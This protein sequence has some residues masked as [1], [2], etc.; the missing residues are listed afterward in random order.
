MEIAN[1]ELSGTIPFGKDD[2]ELRDM[3]FDELCDAKLTN[4]CYRKSADGNFLGLITNGN[5]HIRSRKKI[6]EEKLTDKT[7]L[8][9]H[10]GMPGLITRCQKIK[11][12]LNKKNLAKVIS[13]TLEESKSTEPAFKFGIIITAM[14]VIFTNFGEDVAER[15]AKAK[16]S[17][18]NCICCGKLFYAVTYHQA[19]CSG[20]CRK[21]EELRR[22]REA[23]KL[24]KEIRMEMTDNED[25]QMEK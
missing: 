3:L 23:R 8:Y 2:S 4:T 6:T 21:T 5:F 18:V 13:F 1:L 17:V 20:T 10:G 15:A 25:P 16:A 14:E 12:I 7:G 24:A 22:L 9:Y 19:Y 11:E